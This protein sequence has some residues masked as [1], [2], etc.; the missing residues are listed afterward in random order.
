MAVTGGGVVRQRLVDR[1]LVDQM[2]L[3]SDAFQIYLAFALAFG[4]AEVACGSA[5]VGGVLRPVPFYIATAVLGTATVIMGFVA[6]IESRKRAGIRK[7]MDDATTEVS[8]NFDL[9]VPQSAPSTSG[10]NI[11]SGP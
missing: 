10:F 3:S 2:V 4:A 8:F 9:G 5:L 11:T 7:G 6:W 1:A